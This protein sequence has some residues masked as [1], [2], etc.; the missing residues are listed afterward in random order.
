MFVSAAQVHAQAPDL[1]EARSILIEQ[2]LSPEQVDEFLGHISG[3]TALGV[4][5]VS[6]AE[7]CEDSNGNDTCDDEENDSEITRCS[8]SYLD[9][10]TKFA[11][12]NYGT[13]LGDD[14]VGIALTCQAS[15][16][17][18]S[19]GRNVDVQESNAILEYWDTVLRQGGASS[20]SLRRRYER[21]ERLPPASRLTELPRDL[22]PLIKNSDERERLAESVHLD[23]RE[24]ERADF[25]LKEYLRL[26]H[27]VNERCENIRRNVGTYYRALYPDDAVCLANVP[28]ADDELEDEE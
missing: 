28:V 25:L 15:A 5:G 9:A 14:P 1:E 4:D 16:V 13:R 19:S 2:G 11:V 24:R 3:A 21:I 23:E 7:G 10:I 22:R 6:K 8:V 18:G 20:S 27:P 26:A 17:G 12:E